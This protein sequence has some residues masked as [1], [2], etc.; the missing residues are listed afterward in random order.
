MGRATA[1]HWVNRLAQLDPAG[2]S[3]SP[4]RGLTRAGCSG[5]GLLP[6]RGTDQTE[7]DCIREDL[8][9]AGPAPRRVVLSGASRIR[10]FG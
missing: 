1:L 5:I 9:A 10:D 2:Y 7:E 3:L 6:P 8:A 4:W